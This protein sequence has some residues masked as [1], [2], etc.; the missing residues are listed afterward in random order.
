MGVL[1]PRLD[2]AIRVA[3]WAHREQTRKSTDLPYIVHPFAVMTIAAKATDDEDVLIACLFH[4][5]IEDVPEMYNREQMEQEFGPQVVAIV[6][7]VTKDDTIKDWR[8]RSEAYL[9]HLRQAS[10][11]SVI[12]S[13]S[14]KI[15][16]L[17]SMLIDHETQGE[18]LWERFNA[19]PRDQLWWYESIAE[20]LDS[21]ISG[22]VLAVE[23]RRLID[24]LRPIVEV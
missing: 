6:D 4:D 19:G 15:H 10:D 1:S 24:K 5:I 3:A 14:D 11:G 9:A 2:K 8:Q 23:L 16:N 13:A 18:K 17:Q 7:G 22:S 12:V 21:R 20:V